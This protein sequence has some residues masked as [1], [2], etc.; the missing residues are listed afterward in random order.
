LRAARRGTGGVAYT[1][2]VLCGLATGL[3]F[4]GVAVAPDGPYAAFWAAAAVV[5]VVWTA[6]VP[7]ALRRAFGVAGDVLAPLGL[8]VTATPGWRPR[9]S[10]GGDLTG[11]LT[12]AG[13]RHGRRVHIEQTT[14]RSVTLVHGSYPRRSVGSPATMASITGEPVRCWRKVSAA[15]GAGGVEVRRTGNGAG[16]WYLY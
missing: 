3:F 2:L 16:R 11:A 14:D 10:G 6:L 12:L 7:V 13:E 9:G 4:A 1:Y 15:A 8:R 5:V